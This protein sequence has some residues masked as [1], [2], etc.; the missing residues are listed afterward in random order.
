[1]IQNFSDF[2]R[3][4]TACG[5]SMS[6][7][8]AKGIYAIIPY[9]WKEQEFVDSPV[10][11]HTGDPETDPWEWRMRVLEERRDIAYSKLFFR[12]GG[13]IVKEWY[14]YFYAVR[15]QGETFDEAYENG[16]VSRTAKRIYA[17][18]SDGPLAIHEIKRLGG[19]DRADNTEF[20]RALVELQ[21]GMFL[22]ICGRAQ[23]TNKNGEGYG[24]NSTVYTTVEDFWETRGFSL[25][26][27]DPAE[28]YD[29]IRAQVLTVN[30]QAQ[31]RK[32]DKFI[33]G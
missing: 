27:L 31:Q 1:M 18:A 13:Y 6:G 12:T 2:C 7:G 25:P 5:F 32:I 20:E 28:S 11:W 22:T 15:R 23:K 19:F 21:T 14:P 3:E 24:W 29:K 8:N 30:P 4:L 33:R 9:N 16:T 26:R 10:K 17:L